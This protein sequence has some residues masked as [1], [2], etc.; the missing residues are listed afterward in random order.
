MSTIRY[1][2]GLDL[3][4]AEPTAECR[5]E[6]LFHIIDRL[7]RFTDAYQ[8]R[9]IS[10]GDAVLECPCED[11]DGD[12]VITAGDDGHG[13]IGGALSTE[14]SAAIIADVD[15][16]SSR[17]HHHHGAAAGALR[18]TM[19]RRAAGGAPASLLRGAAARIFR[20][21]RIGDHGQCALCGL[22]FSTVMGNY[23][24]VSFSPGVAAMSK[25]GVVELIPLAELKTVAP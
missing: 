23:M 12:R 20:T 14:E 22:T 7:V 19:A 9:E 11:V 13:P 25:D 2:L 1:R 24:S 17:R 15:R 18:R 21:R 4:F 5:D 16:G 10:A 8:L 6:L 3:A